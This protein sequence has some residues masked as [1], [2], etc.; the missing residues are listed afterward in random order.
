[1]KL[2][3]TL[4]WLLGFLWSLPM[5]PV[6]LL[7]MLYYKPRRVRWHKG[8]LEFLAS[9]KRDKDGE[10]LVDDEGYK[11]TRIFGNPGGQCLG[12][13]VVGYADERCWDDPP[14]RIHERRHCVQGMILG[15]LFGP[16]YG[17]HWL[18][19]RVFDVPDE[20]A[21]MPAWKRAYRAIWFEEDARRH[22]KMHVLDG[23][24]A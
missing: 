8:C 17:G 16:L 18:L 11:I 13:P 1:M 2:L 9:Y 12:V 19:I 4:G 23:W 5:L 3:R 7:L 24:G 22:A 14:L 20:P 6:A 10:I 21:D 15:I